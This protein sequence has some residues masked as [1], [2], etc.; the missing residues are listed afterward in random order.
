MSRMGLSFDDAH[1]GLRR[2]NAGILRPNKRSPGVFRWIT[3]A[4]WVPKRALL[5]SCIALL[6]TPEGT[7]IARLDE[8][9]EIIVWGQQRLSL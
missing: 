4:V 7:D 6:T 3:A 8:A 1:R 5:L 2:V 9:G